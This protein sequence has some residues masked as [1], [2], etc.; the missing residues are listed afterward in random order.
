MSFPLAITLEFF[1]DGVWV[2]VTR[3]DDD[4]HVLGLDGATAFT[5]TK[6]QSKFGASN[7]SPD[8]IIFDYLDNNAI[9]NGQNPLSPYAGKIGQYTPV[10]VLIDATV[11][12]IGEL[13]SIIPR[14]DDTGSRVVATI[15]ANSIDRRIGQGKK[16][17]KPP[18]ERTILAADP[19][20][21]WK[22]D[23]GVDATQAGSTLL[24]GLPMV[25]TGTMAFEAVDGP[26]GQGKRPELLDAT[27]AYTGQLTGAVNLTSDTF[28]QIDVSVRGEPH[29]T[30]LNDQMNALGFDI[31]DT[32]KFVRG[33]LNLVHDNGASATQINVYFYDSAGNITTF[34]A[35]SGYQVIDGDWHHIT[36]KMSQGSGDFDMELWADGVIVNSASSISGSIGR[37]SVPYTPGRVVDGAVNNFTSLSVA[38]LAVFNN[39]SDPA[40]RYQGAIG[41][42]GETA[43]RR[44]ERLFSEHSI[45]F[46]AIG[47]LDDTASMGVQT[48]Q[49]LLDLAYDAV[50]VDGGILYQK[51]D[52]LEFVYRTRVSLYG[53]TPELEITYAAPTAHISPEFLPRFTDIARRNDVTF[54]RPKGSSA[55][56]IIPD[57]DPLHFTTQDPPVGMGTAD[58]A[59]DRNVATDSQLNDHA[60]WWAHLGSWKETVISPLVIALHRPVWV[61]DTARTAAV[62][63]LGIGDMVQTITTGAPRWVEYSSVRGLIL[64]YTRVFAQFNDSFEFHT[65]PADAWEVEV[66]DADSTLVAAIDDNDTSLKVATS[67]GDAWSTTDEPYYWHIGGDAMKVTAL[68]TDTVVFIAA[69]TVDHDDNATVTPGIPAGMTPDVGQALL[70]FAAIRN[71][72]T[73]TVNLPTGYRELARVANLLVFGKYYVTGDTTPSVSFTGGAAG[74]TTTAVLTGWSGISLEL[75]DG[76][77]LSLIA[78]PQ[79]ILNSSAQNVAWPAL[80]VRRTGSASMII[81]WKQDDSTDFAGPGVMDA[82]LVDA[83]TTTGDDQSISW[84]VKHNAPDLAA[85]SIVVSGGA[86]AISRA[87][88]LALRPLQTATVERGINASAASHAAGDAIHA[89]RLGLNAL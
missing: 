61:A 67:A 62:R 86:A 48:Q 28:W 56:Y 59:E 42:A 3:I 15:T 26:L 25:L 29:S 88:T 13:A 79:Y 20:A 21:F 71:S 46:S 77:Y 1:I 51:H 5:V 68:V 9:L 36:I 82:E 41:H 38:N 8:S 52:A 40:E 39:D 78:S 72:G 74:A 12:A 64:G 55:R 57:D 60:A 6:G 53:Q 10:R 45:A 24:N 49:T 81:S 2:D 14:W 17:L 4:T 75:D 47:D 50:E 37:V 66:T 87:I 63:A 65:T 70:G 33:E 16:P 35:D 34:L 83:S 27:S 76:D 11:V 84:Y 30:G 58:V 19:V 32:T 69:G 54:T 43:G 7:R 85:G 44:L 80:S 31:A 73:G 22:L 89:W 18:A 23:D